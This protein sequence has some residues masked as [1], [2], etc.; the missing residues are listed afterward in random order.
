MDRVSADLAERYGT[1][2][3]GRRTALVAGATVLAVGFLGWLAWATW[4]HANPSVESE[5]ST[6]RIVDQHEAGAVIDVSLAD[7]TEA[8]CRVRALARDHSVVGELSF[9]PRDGS[10]AVSVRTERIA[11]TVDL[12][13]CTAEGQ[14]RSR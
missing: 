11:T 6:Y 5:L 7:G 3:P 1:R 4:F 10:N 9:T 12:V 14:P 13:G 8:S 2:R